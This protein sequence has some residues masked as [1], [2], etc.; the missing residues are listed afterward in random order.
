MCNYFRGKNTSHSSKKNTRT[1][2]LAT[3]DAEPI[4]HVAQN[5]AKQ[6]RRGG[7]KNGSLLLGRVHRRGAHE[8]NLSTPTNLLLFFALK[9]LQR[10]SQKEDEGVGPTR[11]PIPKQM[12]CEF[13]VGAGH[14]FAENQ[15]AISEWENNR[16]V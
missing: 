6:R 15:G 7:V 12:I 16:R 11:V 9:A 8:L 4:R 13:G 5:N 14:T 1:F 3:I 10:R 2:F